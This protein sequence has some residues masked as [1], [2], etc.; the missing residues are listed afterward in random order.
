MESKTPVG[1][2]NSKQVNYV[3]KQIIHHETIGKEKKFEMKN[4]K[5]DYTFSP[6]TCNLDNNHN[7]I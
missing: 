3:H 5:F 2:K 7:H 6:Y 1:N 4:F